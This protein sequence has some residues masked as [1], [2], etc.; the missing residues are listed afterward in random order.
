M[1]EKLYIQ[2]YCKIKNN[3]VTLNGKVIFENDTFDI[4]SFLKNI[5]KNLE[6]KY[7]KF[8]KM[9][10]LSK[11]AFLSA[12]YLLKETVLENKNIAIVFSNNASSLDTDRKHQ[13]SINDNQNYFPS[14]AVFVY[15]LPNI[16][17]G[18]ISIKHQLKSENAFFIFEKYNANFHH[19]YENNL[20]KN[21]KCDAVLAGW[22]NI[23][24]NSYEAF[25][26]LVSENGVIEHSEKKLIE[27]YNN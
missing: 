17:I 27:L 22:V 18:E 19:I 3:K 21:K 10:R 26:Y 15:T 2:S 16:G 7:P 20:V 12:E 4:N 9:D 13:D 1:N 11:L 23:D 8:F 6:I 25:L 24:E 5:Y 14:P